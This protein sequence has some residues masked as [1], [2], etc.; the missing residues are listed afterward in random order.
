MVMGDTTH[1]GEL[2]PYSPSNGSEGDRFMTEW[3]G[4][5]AS[6][7]FDDP[8][9]CCPIMGAAMAFSIGDPEYPAEWQY[10]NAGVPQCAAFKETI[11]T[12][13]RCPET[14]DMFKGDTP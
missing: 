11:T 3:C 7:D 4:K 2:R 5:C 10:S 12:D 9:A 8:D 13:E 1:A 6:M 14:P